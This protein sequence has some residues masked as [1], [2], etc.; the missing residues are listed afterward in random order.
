MT[1]VGGGQ[2]QRE[3]ELRLLQTWH[4]QAVYALSTGLDHV[5]S[6]D[7]RPGSTGPS[8]ADPSLWSHRPARLG[9]NPNSASFKCR[10]HLPGPQPRI[11]SSVH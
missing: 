11:T 3:A 6:E 9:T 7:P 5:V 2:G 4:P 1:N 10:L 8:D